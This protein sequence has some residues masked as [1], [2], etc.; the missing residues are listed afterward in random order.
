MQMWQ[1]E[2]VPRLPEAEARTWQA[3][4]QAVNQNRVAH[5]PTA[6]LAGGKAGTAS[7]VPLWRGEL[8]AVLK[9]QPWVEK[10]GCRAGT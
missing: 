8:A 4:G 2:A 7:L 6:V 3:G 5:S 1:R 9:A 10:A